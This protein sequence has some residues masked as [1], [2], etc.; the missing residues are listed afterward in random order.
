MNNL[1]KLATIG[2]IF[3][4]INGCSTVP[5]TGRSQLSLVPESQMMSLSLTSYNDF[6][7]KNP[8]ISSDNVSAKRVAIVGSRIADAVTQFMADNGMSN[9]LEGYQWE[10][11]MIDSKD[12]NAWCMPGGKVVVYSGLLPV[13]KDD[14]GLAIVMGHE[15]AHAVAR[16]GS[17]RMSQQL[18]IQ[19][20]GASLD[21]AL[22]QKPETTKLIYEQVFGLGSQVGSL[23]Y[24]RKHEYEADELGLI[25]AAMAGYDPNRAI[26]FWQDMSANS[27]GA[28]PPEFLS[29]HPSDQNRIEKLNSL[30][31]KVMKYYKGPPAVIKSKV[32]QKQGK[33]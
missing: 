27:G 20:G 16:H 7:K 22:Q 13:C 9:R 11:K 14:A 3:T 8:P 6:L 5:I 10:F 1:V 15:I 26:S 30:M 2:I 28:K 25:F 17:E 32:I 21:L 31:P 18:L 33:N 12:V 24:S 19:L 4:V 29:T 23:A